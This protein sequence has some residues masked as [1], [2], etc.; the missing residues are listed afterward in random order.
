MPSPGAFDLI[1]L[2]FITPTIFLSIRRALMHGSRTEARLDPTVR[3]L[4]DIDRRLPEGAGDEPTRSS[5]AEY[6]QHR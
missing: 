4:D 3:N 5:G 1:V 2:L 6:R